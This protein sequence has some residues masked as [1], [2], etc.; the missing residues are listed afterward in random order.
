M[1]AGAK[2]LIYL[3]FLVAFAASPLPLAHAQPAGHNAG[4]YARLDL[5]WG[6]ARDADAT[7]GAITGRLDETGDSPI[8][9]AGIG[10]RFNPHLRADLTT[11]YAWGYKLDDTDQGGRAY[12]ADIDA[13]TTLLNLYLEYPLGDWS[14]YLT[15]GAG[16]SRNKTGTVT[17]GGLASVGGDTKTA[18]AW[19]AGLGVGYAVAPAWTID[20]GY[21]YLDAGGFKSGD[22]ASD[23]TTG[24]AVSGELRSHVAL[25]SLRYSFGG[26]APAPLAVPAAMPSP[27][28]APEPARPMGPG[29]PELPVLYRVFFDWNKSDISTE[30]ARILG[31]AAR[32]AKA[33]E[34]Q[35]TRIVATGHADRSGPDRYNM[36][37]SLRRANAVKS[38]LIREG[39]P[40]TRIVVI[41]KG[42]SETLTPT[43]DGVREQ[44]NRRV[45]IVIE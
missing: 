45:E 13:W 37:L 12:S 1:R 14:P 25:L 20:L 39:V 22:Q 4:Y 15:A 21:R 24:S 43:A 8:V 38:M 41:G 2:P 16:V 27:A 44:L 32:T 10:Y 40:E 30:T 7:G 29:V 9:G 17:R 42:E 28:A 35:V 36:A 11:G 3:S 34:A 33:A 31:D 23:G 19:Q 26:P 5:G 18:F 6:F